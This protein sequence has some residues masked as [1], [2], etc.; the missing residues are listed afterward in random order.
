[1]KHAMNLA[2]EYEQTVDLIRRLTAGLPAMWH[3]ADAAD[4][5][6]SRGEGRR[7]LTAQ[8][9]CCSPWKG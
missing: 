2:L 1:M 3:C 4:V 7:A 9:G 6:V 8:G 5:G